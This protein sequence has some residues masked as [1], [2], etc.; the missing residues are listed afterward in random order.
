MFTKSL[1]ILLSFAARLVEAGFGESLP[2]ALGGP[3]RR[4]PHSLV[5]RSRSKSCSLKPSTTTTSTGASTPTPGNGNG[6]NGGNGGV[7]SVAPGKCG[8]P[9]GTSKPSFCVIKG[10]GF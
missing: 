4:S 3:R 7:I 9:N 6:G 10:I 8:K 2:R 1:I 5:K